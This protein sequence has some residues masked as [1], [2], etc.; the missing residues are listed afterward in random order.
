MGYKFWSE[1]LIFQNSRLQSVELL[2]M[3]LREIT[4]G[5]CK[6]AGSNSDYIA[7]IDRMSE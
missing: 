1:D 7:L 4:Y 6:D 3:N 5:L 2:M